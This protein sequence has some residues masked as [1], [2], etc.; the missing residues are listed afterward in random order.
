[1]SELPR[2]EKLSLYELTDE[3]FDDHIATGQHFVDFYAPWCS[4]CKHLEPVWN[5]LASVFSTDAAVTIAKVCCIFSLQQLQ[6][7]FCGHYTWQ[8]QLRTGGFC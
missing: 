6:Q 4:H 3:T 1:M 2:V 8:P 5:E 7:P